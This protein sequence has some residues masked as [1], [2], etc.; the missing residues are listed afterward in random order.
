MREFCFDLGCGLRFLRG[1][2]RNGGFGAR[3][4]TRAGIPDLLR[5]DLRLAE[6][7]EIFVDRVFGVESEMFGVGANESFIEDAPGEA[8]EI[9]FLDGLQHARA[10]LGDVGNIFEREF[11]GLARLAKFFSELAHGDGACKSDIETMIGQP[12]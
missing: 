8:F 9:F 10:N 3:I 7:V 4:D 12:G 1:L 5:V 11:F 6:T 2:G